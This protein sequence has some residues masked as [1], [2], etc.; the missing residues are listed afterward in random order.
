MGNF[1]NTIYVLQ[2]FEAALSV[3]ETLLEKDALHK[4]ALLS[5]MGRIHLQVYLQKL[6]G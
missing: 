3:Y 6:D 5:G 4:V 1:G 2:D